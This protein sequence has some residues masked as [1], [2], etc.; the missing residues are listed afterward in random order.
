K[1]MP[2]EDQPLTYTMSGIEM[3]NPANLVLEPFFR[4][5][6]SRYMVYWRIITGDESGVKPEAR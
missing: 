6:D 3:L 1:L 4:I 2:V 5:H